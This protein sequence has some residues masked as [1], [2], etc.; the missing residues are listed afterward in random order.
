MEHPPLFAAVRK[1][2]VE[3][4]EAKEAWGSSDLFTH[5]ELICI[6]YHVHYTTH[7]GIPGL[8]TFV[9]LINIY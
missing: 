5:M 7:I 2:E 4:L 8:F 1:I 3:D 9:S 6:L